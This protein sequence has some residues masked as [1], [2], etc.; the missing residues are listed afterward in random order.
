[1]DHDG[2]R[3]RLLAGRAARDPRP[4]RARPRLGGEDRR[5]R[6]VA[7][8]GEHRLVAEELRDADQQLAEHQRG[9]LG[10]GLEVGGVGRQVRQVVHR[11]AARQPALERARLVLP[12]SWPCV[13]QG[14][15]DRQRARS[16]ASAAFGARR[17]CRG[18]RRRQIARGRAHRRRHRG[19]RRLWHAR[20]RRR[21]RVLHQHRAAR[22]GDRRDPGRAVGAHARQ[23][24]ADRPRAARGGQAGEE[25][26]D[27]RARAAAARDRAQLQ[28][29]ADERQ[30]AP[31]RDH[32]DRVG[33]EHH[34][35]DDLA[36][37]HRGRALQQL[38]QQRDVIGIEVGDDH[39]GQAG[40]DRR[41][42]EEL[43]ERLA[44]A[45][46]RA[47]PDD[48]DRLAGRARPPATLRRPGAHGAHLTPSAARAPAR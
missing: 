39:V 4:H 38:R 26:V 34:A 24:H 20:E 17:A 29:I 45:G 25:A 2:Q 28:A 32:V 18:H 47:Q 22:R 9:L 16:G 7:Q 48:V 42:G 15:D 12:R 44:A 33:R 19:Q 3:V 13:T 27:Q 35:V 11:D 31:R 6:L 5:Q 46:R 41:A 14:H 30:R 40:V 8:H 23:H 36:H 21:R 37:R 1:V 10:R 43:L